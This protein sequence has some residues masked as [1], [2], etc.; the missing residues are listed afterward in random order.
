MR[1]AAD[2]YADATISVVCYTLKDKALDVSKKRLLSFVLYCLPR[3]YQEFRNTF[4]RILS[5]VEVD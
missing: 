1:V 2:E 4:Y 5:S 3:D